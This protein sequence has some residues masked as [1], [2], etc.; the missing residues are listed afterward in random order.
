MK[1]NLIC[2]IVQIFIIS[3]SAWFGLDI[4]LGALFALILFWM[5]R[6]SKARALLI[7]G[8]AWVGSSIFWGMLFV[9]VLRLVFALDE[10]IALMIAI[11][12]TLALLFPFCVFILPKHLRK[13]GI[14]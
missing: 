11:P 1:W 2:S 13:S 9:G 8:C 5:L 12:I 7:I 4:F 14:L 6:F 10:N 3:S